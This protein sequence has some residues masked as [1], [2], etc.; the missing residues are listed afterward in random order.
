[1][2]ISTA[3]AWNRPLTSKA[4]I[5]D[6]GFR[7][8]VTLGKPLGEIRLTHFSKGLERK[9]ETEDNHMVNL[10]LQR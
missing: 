5:F 10:V 6:R 3:S 7:P 1:M 4:N 2:P 8:R 9:D